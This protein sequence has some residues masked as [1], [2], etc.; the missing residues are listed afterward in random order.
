MLIL[1]LPQRWLSRNSILATDLESIRSRDGNLDLRV[2]PFL[3]ID[4]T[5]TRI[6]TTF[7]TS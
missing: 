2:G 4:F 7:Q 5:S 3:L 1:L 6:K